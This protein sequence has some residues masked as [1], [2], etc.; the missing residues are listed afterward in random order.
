MMHRSHITTSRA[1]YW[2]QITLD[3]RMYKAMH[4]APGSRAECSWRA[5]TLR[6]G[7]TISR[8]SK[9]CAAALHAL[10]TL[11]AS[12]GCWTPSKG[13]VISCVL[14]MTKEKV[15]GPDSG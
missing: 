6:K 5:S 3:H 8:E 11:R 2:R 12:N 1:K 9:A 4:I 7:K 15:F 10:P 14:N 13:K